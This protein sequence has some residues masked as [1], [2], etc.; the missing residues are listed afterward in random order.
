MHY[1]GV[2][3]IT[4]KCFDFDFIAFPFDVQECYFVV[5]SRAGMLN[6]DITAINGYVK[7]EKIESDNTLQY[8]IEHSMVGPN[9]ETFPP[10]NRSNTS[11]IGIKFRLTRHFQPYIR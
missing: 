4:V 6:R 1:H 2:Y 3:R 5:F 11:Y 7:T 9:K 8:S 10:L